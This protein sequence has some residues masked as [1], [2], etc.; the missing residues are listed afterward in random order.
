MMFYI[1]VTYISFSLTI[2]QIVTSTT[3]G[4]MPEQRTLQYPDM[5]A[6]SGQIMLAPLMS[7][8]YLN[9]Q[10]KMPKITAANPLVIIGIFFVTQLTQVILG[11]FV[12]SINAECKIHFAT[13]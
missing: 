5:P 12:E 1:F 11:N 7:L 6:I 9:L 2:L 10:L 3:Y 13:H 8:T 4:I